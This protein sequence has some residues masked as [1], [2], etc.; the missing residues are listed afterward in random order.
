MDT[1]GVCADLYAAAADDDDLLDKKT[2]L[3]Q[4]RFCIDNSAIEHNHF[5]NFPNHMD[6]DSDQ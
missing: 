4:L 1:G 6:S 3:L 2:L 5:E